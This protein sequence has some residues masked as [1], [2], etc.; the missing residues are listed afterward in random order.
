M[1]AATANIEFAVWK[2]TGRVVDLS[3]QFLAHMGKAM[4]L[5]AEWNDVSSR[6]I[7]ATES[8]VGGTDGGEYSGTN[9]DGVAIPVESVLPYREVV[10]YSPPLGNPAWLK[11]YNVNRFNFDETI[12]PRAALNGNNYYQATGYRKIDDGKDPVKCEEVLNSGWPMVW[13]MQVKGDITLPIWQPLERPDSLGGHAMLIV[14]YDNRGES[15]QTK[16]F[17]VKNSW[18]PGPH[19]DGLTKVSYAYYKKYGTFGHAISGVRTVARPGYPFLGRWKLNSPMVNGLLDV[20]HLPGT[21][22]SAWK[23][24]GKPTQVDHRI[25]LLS[26]TSGEFTDRTTMLRVNGDIGTR[27][28]NFHYSLTNRNQS[29][30]DEPKADSQRGWVNVFSEGGLMAGFIKVGPTITATVAS[31]DPLPAATAISGSDATSLPGTYTLQAG[32]LRGTL[33]IAGATSSGARLEFPVS[34]TIG[35]R[36]Y[37]GTASLTDASSQLRGGPFSIDTPQWVFSLTGSPSSRVDERA[38]TRVVLVGGR[39][40]LGVARFA[41]LTTGYDGFVLW[42]AR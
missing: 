11:Q 42:R 41:G 28:L 2:T 5:H 26:F 13:D 12:L 22:Q 19:R 21:T 17:W 40:N 20:S 29:Y 16:F 6:G 33:T 25:G 3:E 32:I 34:G 30:W 27:G 18:G 1:F 8:Q 38:P 14:G 9:A 39:P 23:Y 36:S 7:G 15:D 31:K 10:P 24:F 4:Y 37:A 35:G